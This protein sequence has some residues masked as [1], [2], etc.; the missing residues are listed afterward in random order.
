MQL[1]RY[2]ASLSR[3]E[4]L[5]FAEALLQARDLLGG[6]LGS[7][8][9]ARTGFSFTVISDIITLRGRGVPTTI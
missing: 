6:E 1:L 5:V 3:S 4:I 7:G 9:A 2:L 8:A